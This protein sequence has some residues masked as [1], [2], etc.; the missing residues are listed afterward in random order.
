[1]SETT[2]GEGRKS[3]N[4]ILFNTKSEFGK[5]IAFC[6]SN[7]AHARGIIQEEFFHDHKIVSGEFYKTYIKTIRKN[8][9]EDI[10]PVMVPDT[11]LKDVQSPLKGK[12]VEVYGEFRSYD[13]KDNERSHLI[14]FLF[15]TS[16]KVCSSDN[17]E[18]INNVCL[19][20]YIC[21]EPYFKRVSRKN[22]AMAS[23]TIKVHRSYDR[24]A[25]I[26][27]VAW[28][29]NAEHIA[30]LNPGE[31]VIIQGIMHSR[32]Y[33]KKASLAP[34]EWEYKTAYEVAAKKIKRVSDLVG[35]KK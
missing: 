28:E 23:F 3:A 24:K 17:L 8:G 25:Y 15:A 31:R 4:N 30:R 10:I 9:K 19:N 16:F 2:L 6:D 14:L 34:E 32:T 7:Q 20:G 35:S 33:L 29:K 18:H 5:I 27:C 21:Q 26:P 11:L 1:M 12:M 13:Q 22:V